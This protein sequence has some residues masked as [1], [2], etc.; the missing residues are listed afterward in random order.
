MTTYDKIIERFKNQKVIAVLL[1]I[2]TIIT[3]AWGVFE[4]CEK[5][6]D[7]ILSNDKPLISDTIATNP[8]NR[9]INNPSKKLPERKTP[10]FEVSIQLSTSEGCKKIFLNGIEI[11]AL[12]SS[13]PFNPRILVS[14]EE[15]KVQKIILISQSEDTCYLNAIFDQNL[16]HNPPLRFFPKCQH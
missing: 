3:S 15:E 6:H 1:V 13:T 2:C 10:T 9:N 4:I 11:Y 8:V 7:K 5:I 16:I 12:P 14:V